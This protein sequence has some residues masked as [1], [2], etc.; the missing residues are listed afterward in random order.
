MSEGPVGSRYPARDNYADYA[1][2]L[3]TDL[4]YDYSL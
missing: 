1:R 4:D 2:P 3:A